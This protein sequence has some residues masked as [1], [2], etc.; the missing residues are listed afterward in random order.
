MVGLMSIFKWTLINMVSAD[1]PWPQNDRSSIGKDGKPT[2]FGGGA[3]EHYNV[4]ILTQED[5]ENLPVKEITDKNCVLFLWTTFPKLQEGLDVLRSWGFKYKTVAFVWVKL[6]K[7]NSRL[8]G[9]MQALADTLINRREPTNILIKLIAASVFFG[10]GSYTKCLSGDT[11]VYIKDINEK[12]SKVKLSHLYLMNYSK[13]K[14]WSPD[15]WKNINDVVYNGK[16]KVNKITTPISSIVATGNHRLLTKT[17]K[18]NRIESYKVGNKRK[19]T[20]YLDFLEV[21][22]I[23][24]RKSLSTEGVRG[25]TNLLFSKMGM[26]SNNPIKEMHEIKLT[27]D[28]GWMIG[29][30]AAEG[31]WGNK[32]GSQTRF[33]LHSKEIDFYNRIDNYINSLNMDGDRYFNSKIKARQYVDGNKMSVYFSS[34]KVKSV[35]KEF[36]IGEGSHGKRLNVELLYNCTLEFR[37]ALLAGIFDGDGYMEQQKYQRITLCN[38]GLIEDIKSIMASVGMP[39]STVYNI[40]A[41][42][43]NNGKIFKSHHLSEYGLTKE[44][45]HNNNNVTTIQIDSIEELVEVEDV[46]DINVDGGEF[47]ANDIVS[48]NSNVEICLLGTKGKVGKLRKDPNGNPIFFDPKERISVQTNYISQLVFAPREKH[49]KKPEVI[50][51]KMIELFGDI[52]RI[53]LFARKYPSC[54]GWDLMG[55]EIDGRDIRD[56]L[57]E[58][59]NDIKG[60]RQDESKSN[61]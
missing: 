38:R 14:I 26:Q 52:P 42:C 58:K 37:N 3:Q 10:V 31:N 33:S 28:L 55:N 27:E 39:A 22:E 5:I 2:K 43:T 30:F 54:D 25:S 20:H 57:S 1:P 16:K 46:Y 17:Y 12:I 47:I 11:L 61:G 34:K 49:S 9:L 50:R 19:T 15:G 53:E 45:N 6:N 18:T 35:I 21:D 7:N 32:D 44:F 36:I 59:I 51:Q 29:L 41:K 56:A 24:R 4:D 13:Y 23:N 60:E 8:G 48:H 40:D